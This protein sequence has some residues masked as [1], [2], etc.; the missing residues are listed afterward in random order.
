MSSNPKTDL[1]PDAIILSRLLREIEGAH[2]IALGPGIPQQARSILPQGIQAVPLNGR[3]AGNGSS[4]DIA[5]VEALEVTPEGDLCEPFGTDLQEVKAGRWIVATRQTQENGQAKIVRQSR[6][7]VSRTQCVN[8]IITELG[9]IR[10]EALG[11]V[12]REVAPGVSS[13]DVR[14]RVEASLHVADD[15]RVMEW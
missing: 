14:Q 6:L 10:V 9:L 4:F 3:P 15:L 8:E 5:V 2:R 1:I 12:L 13:D 11:F 7:P